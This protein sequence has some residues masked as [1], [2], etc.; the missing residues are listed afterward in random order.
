MRQAARVIKKI[1]TDEHGD[2]RGVTSVGDELFVLLDRSDNQL[3]VYSINDYQL[4]RHLDLPRFKPHDMTS[5]V[6]HRCLYM[7][8][9]DNRCIHRY[10]LASSAISK[11]SVADTPCGLSVT[12]GCECNLLVTCR[13]RPNKLVEL[14]ADSGQCVREI[15]LQSDV[16]CPWHCVQLT[17]GQFVV[18]HG[19]RHDGPHRVCVVGDDGK[20]RL[21]YGGHCGSVAGHLNCPCRLAVDKDLQFIFVADY[22][23]HR[24][25]LLSP[26]LQFVRNVTGELSCP[27]RLFYCQTTRRLFVGHWGGGVTVFQL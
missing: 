9:G 14:S 13:G 18:C 24:V 25:V 2:V 4:L 20:V 10:H 16:V 27:G 1:S 22:D 5:C 6:R 8:D 23:N 26:T 21:S 3:A 15:E 19:L 7:S 11:W 17:T 12:P